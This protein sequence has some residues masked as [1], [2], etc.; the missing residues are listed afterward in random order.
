MRQ[1][2]GK[3]REINEKQLKKHK[4]DLKKLNSNLEYN[5]DLIEKQKYVQK[6]DD[7]WRPFL[8]ERKDFEDSNVIKSI[9]EEVK[10]SIEMIELLEKQL[11]EGVDTPNIVN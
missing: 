5:K 8:R 6:L 1:L 11:N 9:N 4:E 2:E 10:L 7:K 3:E